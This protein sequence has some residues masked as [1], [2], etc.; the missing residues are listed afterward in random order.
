MKEKLN[1]IM[2]IDDDEPTNFISTMLIEEAGCTKDLH[3]VESGVTALQFLTDVSS[4]N[5]NNKCLPDLIFLDLNMPRING[6]EFL[7]QYK[8]VVNGRQ[9]KPVVIMLTTSINPDDRLRAE[10]I[11][12]LTGYENKPLTAD[13]LR[14][15]VHTYFENGRVK[16]GTIQKEQRCPVQETADE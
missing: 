8:K 14:R 6:W 7:E 4:D 5:N 13:M 12:E 1:C 9:K 15:I 16:L 3:V 2:V 10:S 11:P